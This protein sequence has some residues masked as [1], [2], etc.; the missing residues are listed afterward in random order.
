MFSGHIAGDVWAEGVASVAT[1]SG[2]YFHT[3]T[4]ILL[5]KPSVCIYTHHVF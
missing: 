1:P 3:F 2:L 4:Y 5:E